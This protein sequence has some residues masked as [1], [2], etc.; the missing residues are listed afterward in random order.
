MILL[1][2]KISGA[3]PV[4]TLP[5]M[6]FIVN[7]KIHVSKTIEQLSEYFAQLL[8]NKT[9]AG[10]DHFNVSLSGGSTPKNIFE[11]LAAFHQKSIPWGKI[12]FFWGDERCVPPTD[13]DSNFKM[14]NDSLLAKL[15]IPAENIF[16]IKG[17]N[18]PQSEADNYN[19][20]LQN[21]IKTENGFPRFDLIMLGLGEDGHTASIFPNQKELLESDKICAVA[22]HPESG[23]KRITLTG[24]VINNAATVVFI[25]TSQKKSKVAGEI[26]SQ[27]GLYK[28]YPAS[29]IDP[30]NGELYWL[31]DQDS[32]PTFLR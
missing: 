12:K 31:L 19:I 9:R 4:K 8:I 23:Q 26:L 3:V 15:E 32:A 18:D 13:S 14:A 10:S 30:E 11:Y 17:E 25:A 5:M 2:G 24:K 7:S 29:F 22:V 20:L 1:K 28:N 21:Q 27:K 16:R 6:G